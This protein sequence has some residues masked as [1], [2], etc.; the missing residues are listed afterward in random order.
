M[1]S[2]EYCFHGAV[3]RTFQQAGKNASVCYSQTCTV[4][5]YIIGVPAAAKAWT[6]SLSHSYN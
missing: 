2:S 5:C 6:Q 1:S 3:H 4:T